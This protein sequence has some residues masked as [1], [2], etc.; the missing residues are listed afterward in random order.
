MCYAVFSTNSY[1]S[2]DVD[3]TPSAVNGGG[4]IPRN[5]DGDGFIVIPGSTDP[6][7]DTIDEVRVCVDKFASTVGDES[8]YVPPSVAN[9]GVHVRCCAD[10]QHCTSPPSA[11]PT[12][13]PS[14][15]Y[16]TRSPTPAP[17]PAP[18]SAPV[19]APTPLPTLSPTIEP[20]IPA[21]PSFLTC[22]ASTCS[23]LGWPARGN[24]DDN[25]QDALVCGATTAV[26]CPQPSFN[27]NA[28]ACL[29]CSGLVDWAEARTYCEA[30]GGRLCTADE[31]LN[32]EVWNEERRTHVACNSLL[33][34][35]L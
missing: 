29:G 6:N 2:C 22:S 23:G 4:T 14:T 27:M 12:H 24:S 13:A 31:V 10:A 30:S 1:Q 7:D 8:Y 28:S 25:D 5:D 9:R 34:R 16:P 18:T 19:P 17:T 26:R 15:V 20:T 32:D 35:V 11:E 33:S 21:V 3:T